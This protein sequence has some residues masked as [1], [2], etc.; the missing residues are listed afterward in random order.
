MLKI[1]KNI[2]S[3]VVLT[4]LLTMSLLSPQHSYAQAN[5]NNTNTNAEPSETVE[6]SGETATEEST[7]TNNESSENTNVRRIPTIYTGD[8]LGEESSAGRY[9]LINIR[10]NLLPGLARWIGG[11]L[12]ALAVLALI[13]S[14]V[15]FLT[16]GG[17]ADSISKA[18]KSA[19]YT[20][21]AL[22]LMMFGY[23]M[24]YLFLTIF[25]P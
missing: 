23:V 25:T 3:I 12:G 14:G 18:A 22:L 11:F 20:L 10:D 4:L 15:L 5:T 6:S 17:D 9:S 21:A 1:F 2:G 19:F 13:W 7:E 16:A 8:L 24:V